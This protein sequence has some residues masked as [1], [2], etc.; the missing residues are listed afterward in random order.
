[1]HKETLHLID[2]VIIIVSL[3]TSLGVGLRFGR[4]QNTT[5]KYFVSAGTIPS[6]AI[7]MSLM[8]TLVSS[9]T[10]LAYPGEGFS[11][12]WIL[13]VQGLMVPIVLLLMVW[14]IVPLYREVIGLSAYEYF[15]KRF[16]VFARLYS[17]IAFVLTHFSKMGTVFFLLALALSNM[18]GANTFLIIWVIG[19][20]VVFITLIGGIEAVIWADV[21]QGFL[22]ILGGVVSLVILLFALKGGPAEVW[23]IAQSNG[24]TGF[25]PYD[26]NFKKLTFIVMVINGV[27]YAIQKYGTDQTMVQRYLTAKNDKS[28]IKATLL[29]VGLTVP[30]W[31][32]F[33]FI[34]T[35]LFVFYKQNP[36]PA[37]MRPDAVFPY[38]IMTN[39][40]PG[41]VGL[42]LAALIS[43]AI[44]SL[45]S[46]LNCL[47]AIGVEDYYKRMFPKKT[48][49]QNLKAGRWIVVF[50]GLGA[51]GI[52]S[53]YL[54]A[55]DEGVLG[56]VFTLYSIFSGGIAGIFLLGLF[57]SR[58]NRQGLLIGVLTCVLFTAYAFLTSTKIGLGKEKHVLLDMGIYSFKQ[59][60]YMLGV[61]SHIIVI[62]VGYLASLF[63]PKPVLNK[64]L[65][66]SGWLEKRRKI[67]AELKQ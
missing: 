36:L 52:A 59:H 21:I 56:I 53:L 35:A 28:A 64:N 57:S 61:Y 45:G 60:K 67:A 33:M 11:S 66:F 55:G 48:D 27:F 42:I 17:S 7:G 65:L 25:G 31:A 63:F 23:H 37:G 46:D 30:L 49:M 58:A 24:K 15:E 51:I 29:G 20:V 9:V 10:F 39:L 16:G 8:A 18:T 26:F 13:L 44:S 5:A 62:V 3:A 47:G 1:M 2:Y 12:N 4:G 50:G 19:F 38:F 41:V 40:P 22:L 32:L 34:G 6:W 54:M 43:A 14:F